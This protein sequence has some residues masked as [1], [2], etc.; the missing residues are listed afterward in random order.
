MVLEPVCSTLSY[1]VVTPVSLHNI[2]R[3]T[4]RVGAIALIE[5]AVS[6]VGADLRF[7][8]D[9]K[10]HTK[11][12]ALAGARIVGYRALNNNSFDARDARVIGLHRVVTTNNHDNCSVRVH[13]V[14]LTLV[15][16][17]TARRVDTAVIRKGRPAEALRPGR[18]TVVIL[19]GARSA[20]VRL[21]SDAS[22]EI[23]P[24][25]LRAV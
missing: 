20:R 5:D 22:S 15:R 17:R 10:V 21:I 4:S 11:G 2:V 24:T 16:L 23:A 14:H 3:A 12:V 9:M 18:A 7:R 1:A 6:H 25:R 8:V 13:A 19:S